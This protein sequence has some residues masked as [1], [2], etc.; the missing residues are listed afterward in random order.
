MPEGDRCCG[1]GGI[2]SV[3]MPEVSNAM[4]VEKLRQAR[5]TDAHLLVTSDP[6]CLIHMRG[7]VDAQMRVEH[8]ATL[9]EALTR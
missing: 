1:F 5:S 9:L 4:T 2:F 3:H 7:L 6:G 8:L